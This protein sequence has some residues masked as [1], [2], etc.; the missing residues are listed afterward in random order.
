M[1]QQ[2]QAL[3]VYPAQ[4]SLVQKWIKIKIESIYL[5][6]VRVD[7]R[8]SVQHLKKSTNVNFAPT[9]DVPWDQSINAATK[10]VGQ[11]VISVSNEISTWAF[12]TATY[13]RAICFCVKL[14]V[15]QKKSSIR[16]AFACLWVLFADMQSE[17]IKNLLFNHSHSTNGDNAFSCKPSGHFIIITHVSGAE[18]FYYFRLFV[19]WHWFTCQKHVHAQIDIH[20]TR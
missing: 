15:E 17:H 14:Y 13:L 4:S 18:S 6:N 2:N 9:I 5:I 19:C 8:R 12:A 3:Q 11:R 20:A 10:R 16:V 7:S 1:P